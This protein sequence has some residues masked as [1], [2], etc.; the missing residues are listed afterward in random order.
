M[1][2]LQRQEQEQVDYLRHREWEHMIEL[3][4]QQGERMASLARVEQAPQNSSP[5]CDT[6]RDCRVAGGEG[7]GREPR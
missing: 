3:R 7:A 6:E 5:A 4:L 1:Q 2:A